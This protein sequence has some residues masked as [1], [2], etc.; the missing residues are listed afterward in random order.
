MT[1]DEKMDVVA[2]AHE[3]GSII[4]AQRAGSDDCDAGMSWKIRTHKA[5]VVTKIDQEYNPAVR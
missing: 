5:S 4:T 1:A 3:A 2:R